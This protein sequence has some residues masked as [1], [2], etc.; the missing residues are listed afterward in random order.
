MLCKQWQ[1]IPKHYEYYYES[2]PPLLSTSLFFKERKSGKSK[3]LFSQPYAIVMKSVIRIRRF[4]E[5]FKA[6]KVQTHIQNTTMVA[7]TYACTY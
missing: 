6:W 1:D 4:I 7:Y 2:Q 3:Q 5:Y